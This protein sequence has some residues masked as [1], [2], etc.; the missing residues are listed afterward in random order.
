MQRTQA[1]VCGFCQQL[2]PKPQVLVREVFE[3][4]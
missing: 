3:H 1:Q 4:V 2:L